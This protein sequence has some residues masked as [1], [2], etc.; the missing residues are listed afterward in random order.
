MYVHDYMHALLQ[1]VCPDQVLRDNLW[2][3]LLRDELRIQYRAAITHSTFLIS[4]ERNG[5]PITL[6]HYFNSTVQN[7]RQDRFFKQ[8]QKH[9]KRMNTVEAN[10]AG[11]FDKRT[12]FEC[13]TLDA[14]KNMSTNMDNSEHVCE[15]L[16]DSIES[17]Y[18]VARKRFVDTLCQ[19]VIYQM[20]L[21]GPDSPLKILSPDRIM[22]LSTD[23]VETIA[24]EDAVTLNQRKVLGRQ[25]Q[26][27]EEALKVLRS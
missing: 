11:F 24:R 5:L 25:L 12:S 4:I 9:S 8:V 1:E 16:L 27:L 18:K 22:T 23:Q 2:D 3:V 15:D 19:H 21:T 13:V 6:N 17:Y 14:L 7:K 20:L 10:E 26:C